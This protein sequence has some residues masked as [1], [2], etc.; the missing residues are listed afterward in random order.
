MGVLAT[1]TT[2]HM[3]WVYISQ[4]WFVMCRIDLHSEITSTNRLT[5][6]VSAY[7]VHQ[8]HPAVACKKV[9]TATCTANNK[10]QH[11]VQ[12]ASLLAYEHITCKPTNTSPTYAHHYMRS[13]GF[14]PSLHQCHAMP[15]T[16]RNSFDPTHTFHHSGLVSSKT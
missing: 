3:W 1:R 13:R 8:S 12:I 5:V 6:R 16:Q 7:M 2:H 15:T 9:H 4:V 11:A 14:T 10:H